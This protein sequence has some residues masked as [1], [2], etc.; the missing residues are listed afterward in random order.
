MKKYIYTVRMQAQ[1]YAR[2][3]ARPKHPLSTPQQQA[4]RHLLQKM[5]QKSP[6]LLAH[7]KQRRSASNLMGDYALHLVAFF[8]TQRASDYIADLGALRGF[9]FE[10]QGLAATLSPEYLVRLMDISGRVEVHLINL[11]YFLRHPNIPRA[12][13]IERLCE[14]LAVFF[15]E[16]SAGDSASVLH[17]LLCMLLENPQI[18]ARLETD[19][20]HHVVISMEKLTAHLSKTQEFYLDFQVCKNKMKRK[21]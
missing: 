16:Q 19:F 13:R 3:C 5:A 17:E 14:H 6:F 8:K 20:L 7:K 21:N 12:K 1:S 10:K 4:V 18:A 15:E 2:P 11:E 9:L